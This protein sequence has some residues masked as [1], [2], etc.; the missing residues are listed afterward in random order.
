M[1]GP[2]TQARVASHVITTTTSHDTALCI[3][4]PRQLWPRIDRLRS[5]YDDAFGKWPPHINLVYPFVQVASLDHAVVAIASELEARLRTQWYD[6]CN[7]SV[8]LDSSGVFPHR[9]HNTIYRKDGDETRVERLR[10]LRKAVS[11]AL[12][13]QSSGDNEYRPHLTVAQSSDAKDTQHKSRLGKVDLLPTLEWQVDTL[14]VLV[15]VQGVQGTVMK[16]WGTIDLRTGSLSRHDHLMSFYEDSMFVTQ[17]EDT[18]YKTGYPRKETMPCHT[19]DEYTKRWTPLSKTPSSRKLMQSKLRVASY[20]VLAEFDFPPSQERYPVLVNTILSQNALADVLVLQ[21]V[22]DNFLCYLLA[23]EDVHTLYRYVSHAPPNQDD[24]EPLPSHLNI[25]VLS[26]MAFDWEWVQFPRDHK[27]SVVARFRDFGRWEDAQSVPLVLAS[28]H[29]T[30]GLS[31]QAVTTRT[32]EVERLLR[33]LI[34]TYKGH[35]WIVA[36]DFNTTTSSLTIKEALKAGHISQQSVKEISRFNDLLE[37]EGLADTWGSPEAGNSSN[38]FSADTLCA[39][40]DGATYDPLNNMLAFKIRD[41]GPGDR[42]QRYDK[43]LLRGEATLKSAGFNRFGFPAEHETTDETSYGSDHWGIRAVLQLSNAA[44]NAAA[45]STDVSP[46]VVP[47]E[48]VRAPEPMQDP[49]LLK[50]ILESM[51]AI[52][53]AEEG[54]RRQAAF[55][56]LRQVVTENLIEGISDASE[57]DRLRSSLIM[58]PVGSWGLGVSTSSSDIDC[59]CIGPLSSSTFFALTTQRIKKASAESALELKLLRRVRANSGVMLE[60]EVMGIRMDLQYCAATAVAEQWP[61]VLKLPANDPIFAL[62]AQTLGKLKALRDLDYLRE[63]IPDLSKFRVAHRAIKT[64]AQSRGIYSAKFGYLGGIQISILLARVCKLLARDYGQ[65]L[66]VPD[67]LCSFFSHYASFDWRNKIAFDPFFHTK[68]N[69]LRSAR[70]PLAILGFFPPALNTTLAATVPSMNAIAR[71]LSKADEFLKED[72]MTWDTFLRGCPAVVDKRQRLVGG[73]ADFVRSYKSFVK[74]E[75]QYWGISLSK[76]SQFVGWLE[77]RCPLLL[78]DMSR[79]LPQLK[80]RIW[81]QRFVEQLD[82]D[83]GEPEAG[84]EEDDQGETREYQGFYLIGLEEDSRTTDQDTRLTAGTMQTI[85]QRFEDI[86]RKDEKYFD[87]KSQWLSTSVI[88]GAD[89]G[90]LTLDERSWGNYTAGDEDEDEDQ[91][92]EEEAEDSASDTHESGQRPQ[93]QKK[94]KKG[95]STKEPNRVVPIAKS[96]A[97]FRTAADVISRLRWDPALDSSDYV[98][99]YEDRFKGAMEKALDAWKGEQTD[100]EF[101]PQHRILYFKRK[102]DGMVVWERRTRKDL[103]FGSGC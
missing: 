48:L 1:E 49:Q 68:L 19:F 56:A 101:I 80:F 61:A 47:V 22:T 23:N 85:L 79:R 63:T 81:P 31:D 90:E 7:P 95:K 71:E 76:G 54:T 30:H 64:W 14:H 50:G 98:V 69:Y 86:I 33:H 59:L 3:V 44:T 89:L 87:A 29:L 102:K 28:V 96:G 55:D 70:E 37:Q 88:Q 13:H 15:R 97:K 58:V 100:E 24:I 74:I 53:A 38:E 2:Q 91:D 11:S 60:L 92:E 94:G 99:G 83:A 77:S 34:Q 12:G 72:G 82:V 32:A 57:H 84:N 5:L 62:P 103:L 26:T 52:P 66:S 4:P 10:A 75:L 35:P 51:G 93:R 45:I 43:I 67:I 21:E 73:A 40:E 17:P 42:P 39:G 36:G 65:D 6:E 9:K 18:A 16:S 46:L 41:T 20:N 25:V 27:G 78:V 8:R